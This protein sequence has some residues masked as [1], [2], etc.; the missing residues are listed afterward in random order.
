MAGASAP[1]CGPCAALL[2]TPRAFKRRRPLDVTFADSGAAAL[3]ER[4][5]LVVVVA[6]LGEQCAGGAVGWGP[7][8]AFSIGTP[9]LPRNSPSETAARFVRVRLCVR[10]QGHAGERDG[11]ADVLQSRDFGIG[12][13]CR[14]DNYDPKV[15]QQSKNAQRQRGGGSDDHARGEVDRDASERRDQEQR[16]VRSYCRA[17]CGDVLRRQRD[18]SQAD[19][20]RRP[21]GDDALDGLELA[22][23]EEELHVHEL[24]GLEGFGD[25]HESDAETGHVYLAM[26]GEAG[27]KGDDDNRGDE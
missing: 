26:G 12:E 27:A 14:R 23:A 21:D 4:F 16:R 5:L 2:E 8:F 20:G 1:G 3:V 15:A 18:Q 9:L 11:E 25:E 24:E 7:C 10:V 17:R 19:H 22:V 6:F 13:D